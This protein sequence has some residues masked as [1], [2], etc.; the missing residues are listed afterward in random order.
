MLLHGKDEQKKDD[1]I[2]GFGRT[3]LFRETKRDKDRKK[4]FRRDRNR[5]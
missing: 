3:E 4:S 2:L 1:N 5:E